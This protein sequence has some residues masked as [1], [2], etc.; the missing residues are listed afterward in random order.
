M[1]PGE[2]QRW[3]LL[4]ATDSENFQ[5][6]LVSEANPQQGPGLNVVAMDGI[7]VPKTYHVAAT[8]PIAAT[9]VR[10]PSWQTRW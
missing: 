7:T 8:I 5:L 1:Q 4:N 9:A 3:R 10:A 6:V 2:V